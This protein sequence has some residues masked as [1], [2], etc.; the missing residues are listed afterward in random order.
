MTFSYDS[1][2]YGTFSRRKWLT[3]HYLNV[4][5]GYKPVFRN[6]PIV[7]I[8]SAGIRTSLLAFIAESASGPID[9]AGFGIG[10]G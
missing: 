2:F 1:A 9:A 3:I 7:Q 4:M 8:D 10:M 5:Y 6:S